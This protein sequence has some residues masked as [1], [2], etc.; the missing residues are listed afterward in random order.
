M[1]LN[2][3]AKLRLWAHFVPE[4]FF[5]YILLE[6]SHQLCL[7]SPLSHR[8]CAEFFGSFDLMANITNIQWGIHQKALAVCSHVTLRLDPPAVTGSLS[9]CL[10]LL[11]SSKFPVISLNGTPANCCYPVC[12][13]SFM[14][15]C[16]SA[17]DTCTVA[18]LR[19]MAPGSPADLFKS[20]HSYT[21]APFCRFTVGAFNQHRCL[22]WFDPKPLSCSNSGWKWK[23]QW[24]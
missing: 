5:F 20:A 4:S 21:I 10:T 14:R 3:T 24:S 12:M 7:E 1:E 23:W 17:T 8:K 9:V 15:V 6:H 11:H 18:S 16:T 2:I 13:P 19:S 22:F